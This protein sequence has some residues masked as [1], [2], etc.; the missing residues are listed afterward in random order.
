MTVAARKEDGIR[1]RARIASGDGTVLF[2]RIKQDTTTRDED[3]QTIKFFG[4]EC[5]IED[6]ATLAMVARLLRV[7]V[8]LEKLINTALDARARENAYW[9][10]KVT[11]KIGPEILEWAL[12]AADDLDED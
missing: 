8:R 2:L 10:R 7:V 9:N 6:D 4:L 5:P 12:E 1:V 3:C 11:R